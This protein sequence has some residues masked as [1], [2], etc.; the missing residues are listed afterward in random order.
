MQ[1]EG[2]GEETG[3]ED[4]EKEHGMQEQI[5]PRQDKYWQVTWDVWLGR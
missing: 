1:E 5:H 3:R 2:R 4:A